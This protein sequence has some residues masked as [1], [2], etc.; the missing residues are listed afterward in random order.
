MKI[1]CVDSAG[2]DSPIRIES[3]RR[4]PLVIKFNESH[5]PYDNTRGVFY[6]STRKVSSVVVTSGGNSYPYTPPDDW[7]G[8]IWN[9]DL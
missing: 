8:V 9:D 6:S 3:R 7:L 2:N 4:G 1:S 5:F